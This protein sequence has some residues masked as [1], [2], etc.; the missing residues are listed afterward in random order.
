MGAGGSK[1]SFLPFT[2]FFHNYPLGIKILLNFGLPCMG[3]KKGVLSFLK[4]QLYL[5]TN[6]VKWVD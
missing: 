6:I 1:S 3:L 4:K 2:E 5:K